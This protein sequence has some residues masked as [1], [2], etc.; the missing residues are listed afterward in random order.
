MYQINK[1]Y[2]KLSWIMENQQN[3]LH[4]EEYKKFQLNIIC[5]QEI[6]K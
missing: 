4:Q 2:T 6:L 3:V 1:K 5:S